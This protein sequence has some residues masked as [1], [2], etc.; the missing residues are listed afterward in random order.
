MKSE[1]MGAGPRTACGKNH[2]DLITLDSHLYCSVHTSPLPGMSSL[3]LLSCQSGPR[4]A[5][6]EA[7]SPDTLE[8][9]VILAQTLVL[10]LGT[11]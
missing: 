1:S 11:K 10:P 4:S 5:S 7:N 6:E 3:Y 2:S 8:L 9:T